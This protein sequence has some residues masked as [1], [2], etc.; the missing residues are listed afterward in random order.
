MCDLSHTVRVV[1]VVRHMI[2]QLPKTAVAA[3]ILAMLL[4]GLLTPHLRR[5][6]EAHGLLD[7]PNGSRR[8]HGR[9]IPRI[10]GVAIVA[11]FYAP[12]V[13]LLFYET[14]L[15]QLFYERG[16]SAY[17]FLVGGIVIAALGVYDDLRGASARS[18]F[19]VQLAVAAGLYC[20]G[21]HIGQVSLPWGTVSL[22]MAALPVT[23]VWI[24]GIINAMNLIDGLDGLAGGIALCAVLTNLVVAMV[25]PEPV[26]T[27]CMASM[28]GALIGFLFYNLNPA[29]IFMGDSGSLF[30]GYVLAVSSI[31][32]NQKSSAAVSTLVPLLALALPITDTLLA[33]GRRALAGQPMFS[34]DKEH[35]HHRLLRLGFSHRKAVLLL[36][37]TSFFLCVT[38][39]ALTFAQ[40]TVVAWVLLV[41]SVV[42][43]FALRRIGFLR[44]GANLLRLRQRNRELQAALDTIAQDLRGAT[45]VA[46]I[47]ESAHVFGSAVSALSVRL[48]LAPPDGIARSGFAT[49]WMCSCAQVNGSLPLRSRFALREELGMLE[50]EW[51]KERGEID[52]D[53][54]RAAEELCKNVAQAVR[55]MSSPR[56]GWI[57][58]VRLQMRAVID[59]WPLLRV[60]AR[61]EPPG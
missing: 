49:H 26:M 22:G 32:T 7:H 20:C 3:F 12:L 6:A 42:A 38:A 51:A 46:Q 43:F 27:L 54:E 28:A 21:F 10:G 4:A 13:G 48:E 47:L 5:F 14:G 37:G 61:R 52:R 55:R 8:I 34:G 19:A 25:R 59:A 60:K 41:L 16:L 36:S 11:A 18:K 40:S 9:A 39:L 30:L 50:V 29:S 23:I 58:P 53:H 24:V 35:I 56:S 44:L 45:S 17:S 1:P 57:E 2:R 31:A 33:M 15:G